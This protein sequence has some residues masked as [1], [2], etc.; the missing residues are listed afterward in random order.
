MAE[1]ELTM[2]NL[3]FRGVN[4]RQANDEILPWEDDRFDTTLTP[5][6]WQKTQ[7]Y[8]TKQIKQYG[9]IYYFT[10]G[11]YLGKIIGDES[12][13]TAN[14]KPLF[15][16]HQAL[17]L[18]INNSKI[19]VSSNFNGRGV[20]LLWDGSSDGWNNSLNFDIPITALADY[21]SGWIFVSNG[22][23]YYTDG[24]QIQNLYTD[25]STKKISR[26]F[27]P[28]SCN[29]LAIYE[30]MLYCANTEVDSN[31]IEKRSLCY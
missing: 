12:T 15:A 26:S 4:T 11:N 25:N 24:Y 30:N 10:N 29:G 9:D 28:I 19:L 21:Q 1:Q 17:C 14:F 20:L 3:R 2:L 27:N 5:A 7:L 6:N 16:K 22:D 18:G 23:V 31:F 13:V 8:W